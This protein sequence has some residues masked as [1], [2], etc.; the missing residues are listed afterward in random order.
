MRYK[1]NVKNNQK[2][3]EYYS[4]ETPVR[5][6]DEILELISDCMENNTERIMLKPEVLTEDFFRLRTGLA[7]E[8]LQKLCNYHIKAAI[9][10]PERSNNLGKFTELML[11]LNRGNALRVCNTIEEAEVW[12]LK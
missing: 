7:G 4:A 3:I 10:L 12:L 9:I 8:L 5:S 11:E 1:V 6:E 2:Y